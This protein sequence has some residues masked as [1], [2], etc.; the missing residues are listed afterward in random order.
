MR[1]FAIAELLGPLA[2][3]WERQVEPLLS[4]LDY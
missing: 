1:D 2:Q 3:V 4:R